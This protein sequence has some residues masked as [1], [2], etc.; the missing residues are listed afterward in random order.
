[1]QSPTSEV[2]TAGIRTLT[3]RKPGCAALTDYDKDCVRQMRL[4][5]KTLENGGL[6]V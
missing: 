5:T 2:S 6:F 1:M 4:L 3:T